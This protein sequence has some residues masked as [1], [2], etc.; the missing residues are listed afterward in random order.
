MIRPIQIGDYGASTVYRLPWETTVHMSTGLC[1]SDPYIAP[2]L[3]ASK[4]ECVVVHGTPHRSDQVAAYDAR[5]VDIWACGIV[6]YCL[7]FQELPWRVAQ[8]TDSLYAAYVAACQSTNS[9]QASCPPTIANLKPR[10]CRPLIRKMLEPDPKLRWK[11]EDVI[12]HTWVKS[13]AVCHEMEKP[14]HVHVYARALAQGQ[15]N[16]SS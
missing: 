9:Q 13:I 11:I 3:F 2:E 7:H 16:G 15:A 6:Y 10:G 14:N 12:G 5:L 1:G 4:R 8:M